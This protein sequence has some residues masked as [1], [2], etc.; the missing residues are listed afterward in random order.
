VFESP[1]VSSPGVAVRFV[2]QALRIPGA[3]LTSLLDTAPLRHKAETV[4]DWNQLRSNIDEQGLTLAVVATSGDNSR[5]V[6]FV[7]QP[8]AAKPLPPSDD[9]RP[10]DYVPAQIGPPHVL[11]S[12]AIPIA[13]TPVEIED[14]ADA[15]GW[16]LD[17]GVRLNAPL[18]PAIALGADAL[19]AVPTHPLEEPAPAPRPN[20]PDGRG[21][22]DIAQAQHRAW[23]G[24]RPD[25]ER[26]SV[27]ED[28]AALCQPAEPGNTRRDGHGGLRHST[29]AWR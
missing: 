5:A 15:R 1:V 8:P 23:A 2:G 26:P 10:I 12:S 28:A 29:A 11:A 3:R 6:V 18:K 24:T 25:A 7:D 14:P 22:A 27:R 20:L 4:V 16:Y 17:G 19:V 13:F 21:C 9:S